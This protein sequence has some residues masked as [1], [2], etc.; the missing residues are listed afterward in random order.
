MYCPYEKVN[1]F[2]E[3]V[4][5]SMS[6]FEEI[7]AEEEAGINALKL[8][9]RELDTKIKSLERAIEQESKKIDALTR[10]KSIAARDV[11]RKT[12][13]I[14]KE[15]ILLH[16]AQAEREAIKKTQKK[17]IDEEKAIKETL[18]KRKQERSQNKKLKENI[19]LINKTP[20]S[21]YED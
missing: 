4:K 6:S 5:T 18:S 15:Y 2:A 21:K 14:Q 9:Q 13:Q 16:N 1:I 3:D 19:S 11:T 8:K 20:N 17:F 10:K 7:I 12:K